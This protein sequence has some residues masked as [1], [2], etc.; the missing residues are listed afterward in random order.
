V[1]SGCSC[2]HCRGNYNGTIAR[3]RIVAWIMILMIL[4]K[5]RENHERSHCYHKEIFHDKLMFNESIYRV[6]KSIGFVNYLHPIREELTPKASPRGIDQRYA[7]GL[8]SAAAIP[9][10]ASPLKIVLF[11]SHLGTDDCGGYC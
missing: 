11:L 5:C 6:A 2:N 10:P 4:C 7:L 3:G 9:P 8:E 1:L